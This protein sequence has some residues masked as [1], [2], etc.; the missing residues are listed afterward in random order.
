[1]AQ[2]TR[3]CHLGPA[4]LLCYSLTLSGR[5]RMQRK[6]KNRGKGWKR[7]TPWL[8][9][10]EICGEVEGAFQKMVALAEKAQK[11]ERTEDCTLESVAVFWLLLS[12]ALFWRLSLRERGI[13]LRFKVSGST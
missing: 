4:Q 6:A 10:L 5:R 11:D 13:L 2:V 12:L 9:K 1:M 8:A 3:I 7:R